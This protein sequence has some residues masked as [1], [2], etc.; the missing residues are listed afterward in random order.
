MRTDTTNIIKSTD[1][2]FT[3][4]EIIAKSERMTVT[5]LS[6]LTGYTK[7]TI[8]RILNT[9]KQL[10]YIHQNS[11]DLSYSASYKLYALGNLVLK[12]D[13]LVDNSRPYLEE[14]F[15]SLNETINLGVMEEERIIYLDKF[16]PNE[17]LRI[18]MGIGLIAPFYCTGLGKSIA[19][20]SPGFSIENSMD[21]IKFTKNTISSSEELEFELELIRNNGFATD[22]EEFKEGLCCVGVPIK[23]PDGVAIASI[24]C[25]YPKFRYKT[26]PVNSLAAKLMDTARKIESQLF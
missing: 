16:V 1:K 25:S 22:L 5:E 11:N 21:F 4:L 17:P 9:L 18:E 26:S 8:Q 23:D 12:N 7:S 15:S 19:A 6:T 2:V 20:F 24:S 10:R 3:V 13:S 14:L